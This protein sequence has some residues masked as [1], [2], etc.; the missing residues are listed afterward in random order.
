MCLIKC[1]VQSQISDR[2]FLKYLWKFSQE[3]GL[4]GFKPRSKKLQM[5]YS[6]CSLEK[7]FMFIYSFIYAADVPFHDILLSKYKK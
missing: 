1:Y 7:L 4:S 6:F 3:T 5:S 2:D